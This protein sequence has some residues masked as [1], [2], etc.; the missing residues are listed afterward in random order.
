MGGWMRG[1]AE[2]GY[3]INIARN[4]AIMQELQ[5]QGLCIYFSILSM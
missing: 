3:G 5:V 1:L 2:G 4:V